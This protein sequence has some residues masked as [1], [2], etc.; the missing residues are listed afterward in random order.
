MT[1]FPKER[2]LLDF[3]SDKSELLKMK[4]GLLRFNTRNVYKNDDNI[5]YSNCKRG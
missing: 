1:G 4:E 3:L 2:A 5:S